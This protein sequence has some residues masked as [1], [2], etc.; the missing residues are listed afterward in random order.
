MLKTLTNAIKIYRLTVACMQIAIIDINFKICLH[1]K[2]TRSENDDRYN[3][4]HTHQEQYVKVIDCKAIH[5]PS[6]IKER[7]W[8]KIL[9]LPVNFPHL[10][11]AF[12]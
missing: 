10:Y 5:E 9:H 8:P 3:V 6:S 11:L 1:I 4:T 7:V 2:R 12:L